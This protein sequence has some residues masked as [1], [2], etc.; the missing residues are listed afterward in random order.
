[1][2]LNVTDITVGDSCARNNIWLVCETHVCLKLVV[3]IKSIGILE[4]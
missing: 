4:T 2:L 3:K 1:M